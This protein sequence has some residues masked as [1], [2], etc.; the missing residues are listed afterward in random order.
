VAANKNQPQHLV[1]L[2]L[3]VVALF[4]MQ[5]PAW[6]SF[7]SESPLVR[8][9]KKNGHTYV[10]YTHLNDAGRARSEIIV[11][12]A[13]EEIRVDTLGTGT[14]DVWEVNLESTNVRA[15][16]P[17]GGQYRRIEILKREKKGV[18]ETHLVLSADRKSYRV[19]SSAYRSYA[20]NNA[21]EEPASVK[22][23]G[24]SAGGRALG[25]LQDAVR[26]LASHS[27][28]EPH[29][30]LKCRL[31]RMRWLL[32]DKKTCG[33]PHWASSLDAMT[34]AVAN[35]ILSSATPADG[36]KREIA[37]LDRY[38]PEN[39]ARMEA[40]V[41][42][43]LLDAESALTPEQ[44]KNFES[45]PSCDPIESIGSV[46]TADIPLLEQS[47]RLVSCE[48]VRSGL[49]TWVGSYRELTKQVVIRKTVDEL[50]VAFKG[51]N[52]VHAYTSVLFHELVHATG[53]NQQKDERIT[54]RIESCCAANDD[55]NIDLK[56]CADVETYRRSVSISPSSPEGQSIELKPEYTPLEEVLSR[57]NRKGWTY[58]EDGHG[59]SASSFLEVREKMMTSLRPGQAT[60]ILNGALGSLNLH[61]AE[62][63]AEFN[64]CRVSKAQNKVCDASCE[65]Y[66]GMGVISSWRQELADYFNLT[67]PKIIK[68][69]NANVNC[70]SLRRDFS[71]AVTFSP[72]ASCKAATA[73]NFNSTQGTAFA[74]N[75][76]GHLMGGK[77]DGSLECFPMVKGGGMAVSSG[78][79]DASPEANTIEDVYIPSYDAAFGKGADDQAPARPKYVPASQ[80]PSSPKPLVVSRAPISVSVMDP[81]RP[82]QVLS[83]PT[84]A[85][86]RTSPL[87]IP[88]EKPAP[89][90]AGA[91]PAVVKSAP[92]T[93]A[94]PAG[95][96][97]LQVKTSDVTPPEPMPALQ[98]PAKAARVEQAV[99]Q[100]Q[101]KAAGNASYHGGEL[102]E[103]SSERADFTKHIG[104]AQALATYGAYVSNKVSGLVIP[105]A[106]ASGK[107]ESPLIAPDEKISIPSGNQ[108]SAGVPLN[109]VGQKAAT[110]QGRSLA[111]PEHTG[112]SPAVSRSQNPER[113]VLTAAKRRGESKEPAPGGGSS[114]GEI[115]DLFVSGAVSQQ[116][117]ISNRQG[118]RS[119]EKPASH[120]FSLQSEHL[121][122]L[123][124][125][126]NRYSEIATHLNESKTQRALIDF[127]FRI[128]DKR[129]V[130]RGSTKPHTTLIYCPDDTL[131]PKQDGC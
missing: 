64:S 49:E 22:T 53:F 72:E 4:F 29:D 120:S 94:R 38:F 124:L 70:D 108:L 91:E 20:L 56:A 115:G 71:N 113:D 86:L 24:P 103:A 104:Q 130:S 15:S 3:F 19:A 84:L 28:Q 111:S 21:F 107:F 16:S 65:A 17:E 101:F 96:T 39:A 7:K 80:I 90:I 57:L 52:A 83:T 12:P 128:I 23:C 63:R 47:H 88:E 110:L 93:E 79:S 126:N 69:Q 10:V 112:I 125:L 77:F 46:K 37:C 26:A 1:S 109:L 116:R 36:H 92:I 5:T 43:R 106:A 48:A 105:T 11:G 13:Y 67:C 9:F 14:A 87:F 34:D 50:P 59:Q 30:A 99:S 40:T 127:N 18:R 81:V 27:D 6:A 33:D 45:T 55:N 41:Y 82:G 42:K 85:S 102:G 44:L 54:H 117:T 129:G 131:K 31:S 32:F 51:F 60:S 100:E 8:T 123:Y 73:R 62:D 58:G 25:K 61:M 95:E 75:I 35:L 121:L 114:P 89:L 119:A 66:C 76:I 78:K 98:A 2:A 122:G 118:G 97:P 74:G 68:K